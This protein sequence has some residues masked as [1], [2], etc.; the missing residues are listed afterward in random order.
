MRRIEAVTL[1]LTRACDM[2]CTYCFEKE[3]GYTNK[4]MSEEI[5][6][7]SIELLLDDSN[8]DIKNLGH[9]ESSHQ[10]RI[11][12][13]GGEPTLNSKVIQKIIERL[14]SVD[15]KCI[16]LH[17]TTNLFNL[18]KKLYHNLNNLATKPNVS[19]NVTA[20]G[21]LC[22]KYHNKDRIDVNHKGTYKNF[23]ENLEYC[24]STYK[25][26]G[27]SVHS[28]ISSSIIPHITEILDN[29]IYE[30]TRLGLRGR[31]TFALVSEATCE[32]YTKEELRYWYE[33]YIN[34]D[35]SQ[36]S[37]EELS[38]LYFPIATSFDLLQNVEITTC[39]AMKTEIFV[40]W[41]GRVEPCHR[42]VELGTNS[43]LSMGNI[44]DIQSFQDLPDFNEFMNIKDGKTEFISEY[45]GTECSKCPINSKCHTCIL[46]NYTEKNGFLYKSKEECI[47]AM[48]I[49]E[50][51]IEYERVRMLRNINHNIEELTKKLDEIGQFTVANTQ[52]LTVVLR[53]LN[54]KESETNGRIIQTT[55]S[56][57][58][59]ENNEISRLP[60]KEG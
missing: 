42:A 12:L 1:M 32:P 44:L 39:R 47:R 37:E 57:K 50:L 60:K 22:E 36:L 45:T 8:L 7:K 41:D 55:H 31:N 14:W 52:A 10:N 26:I 19:V 34:R 3:Q 59:G 9:I 18:N 58:C 13:F 56:D 33:D 46:A 29:S 35:K 30:C 6:M 4:W 23:I 43:E 48:T 40:D 49:A 25:N 15:D 16:N 5:A 54:D 28:V 17:I 24:T 27:F 11:D 20:S 21:I 53:L 38:E 2:R 51:T